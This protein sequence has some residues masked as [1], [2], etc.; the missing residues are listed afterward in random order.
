MKDY[1]K[2]NDIRNE[3]NFENL[4]HFA[5]KENLLKNINK[6]AIPILNLKKIKNFLIA[7]VEEKLLLV[8]LESLPYRII[9]DPTNGCNLGCPLCPTGLGVSER[10]KGMLKF[11]QFKKIIDESKDYCIELHLYNWGEPTLNKS[12]I[13]MIKY[14]K[15]YGI[16]SRISSNLS[17]NYKENY[18]EELVSSGLSLLHVDVDGIDQEVYEKYRKKGNLNLVINNVKKI[19]DIKKKLN[20]NE[21]VLELS[22]LAMKQNEHQHNDFLK[23]ANE[24]KV[25]EAR[26]DKI[27]YNPNMSKEW[28]PVNKDLIYNTY[29]DGLANSNSAKDEEKKPCHWPWSGIVI[30]WDG[31]INP[32]CIIDDPNS[33]FAN[34]LEKNIKEVWN[35]DEY[36]SSRSEFGDQKNISKNTICNIC[37]NQTHSKKLNRLS[38]SFAIKL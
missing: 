28:L 25:D 11:E 1:W 16:W 4:Y 13:E 31:G 5:K 24:L 30:N 20:I 34:I 38:T 6:F 33:D 23:M 21:P 8:K 19:V 15:K 29:E 35:S 36:I 37:K 14:A 3:T 32:C 27:Q 26:I 2:I 7:C 18:L 12:L 9:I 17:L 22:M 10:K